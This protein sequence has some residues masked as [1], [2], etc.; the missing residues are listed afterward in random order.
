MCTCSYI[1]TH[2][3]ISSSLCSNTN[4][5]QTQSR[6]SR[7]AVVGAAGSMTQPRNVQD[8]R[9]GVHVPARLLLQ[10]GH[11]TQ[12]LGL[13]ALQSCQAGNDCLTLQTQHVHKLHTADISARKDIV[14]TG[15]RCLQ[16]L[17]NSG[18]HARCPDFSQDKMIDPFSDQKADC[19]SG[20]RHQVQVG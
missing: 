17:C 16:E 13:Q 19:S 6:A 15:L 14:E 3:N 2:S 20:P 1:F 7:K 12:G 8:A 10:V 18:L 11:L 9:G 5:N 4:S